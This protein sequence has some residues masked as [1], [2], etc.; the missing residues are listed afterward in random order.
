MNEAVMDFCVGASFH[1][2]GVSAHSGMGLHKYL[3]LCSVLKKWTRS[4][5]ECPYGL[6]VQK[7]SIY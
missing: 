5:L 4:F 6:V 1:F 2:S 7:G 3:H